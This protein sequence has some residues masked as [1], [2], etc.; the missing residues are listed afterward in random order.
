MLS[1]LRIIATYQAISEFLSPLIGRRA[2]VDSGRH[3]AHV[4]G[5]AG[6]RSVHNDGGHGSSSRQMDVGRKD[7]KEIKEM[8]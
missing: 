7:E 8:A 1:I 2:P 5:E 3:V 4:C 6:F